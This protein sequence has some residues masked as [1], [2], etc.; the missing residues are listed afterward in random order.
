MKKKLEVQLF[1]RPYNSTWHS[2]TLCMKVGLISGLMLMDTG[3]SN[4]LRSQTTLSKL[5]NAA[6]ATVEACEAFD[7]FAIYFFLFQAQ[8]QSNNFNVGGVQ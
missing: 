5:E 4:N 6:M 3:R 8:C 7:T 1:N 2:H